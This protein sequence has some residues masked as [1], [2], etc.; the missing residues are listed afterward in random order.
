[1]KRRSFFTS[2]PVVSAAAQVRAADEPATTAPLVRTPPVLMAPRADGIEVIWAVSRLSRGQVEW[3]ADDGTSG[4]ARSDA[5]GFCPQGQ[6]ILR[7]RLNHLQ[8]GT[9]YSLRTIT[10][11]ADGGN[12]R[13]ESPWKSFRTLDPDGATTKFCVWNDTHEQAETIKSLQE[14]TP[15]ADFLI[16]NGDTCN[17]WTQPEKLVP[18]LLHPADQD[19]T[20]GRPLFLTW[21][22]HDVRGR[23]AFRVPEMIATPE[24]RPFFAFRSGPVAVLCL[25][26]GEDKPDAHPSFAGRVAFE[27]LRREQAEWIKEITKRPEFRDAPYRVVFCHIPL[28]WTNEPETVDYG[29]GGYDGYARSSRDLWHDALVAWKTQVAISGHTHRPALIPANESFPYVQMVG[30]GPKPDQATWME[31]QADTKNL[32]VTIKNLAGDVVETVEFSALA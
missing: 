10:E 2:L 30:G 28:R 15:S 3:K 8:P 13:K 18:T 1:M 4:V 31:G 7:V 11:A 25:H 22:N 9:A 29:G 27:A 12:E 19:F 32:R 23:W 6:E 26:T 5:F 16:W 20:N 21:G 24:G 14:K 17:D